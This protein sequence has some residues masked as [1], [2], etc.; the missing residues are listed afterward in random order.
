MVCKKKFQTQVTLVSV[1]SESSV[2]SCGSACWVLLE[3]V[4]GSAVAFCSPLAKCPQADSVR[5]A[6]A[7][8]SSAFSNSPMVSHLLSF[9]LGPPRTPS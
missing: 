9:Q 1:T 7:Q 6:V 8:Q 2:L 5:P 4:M 3:R